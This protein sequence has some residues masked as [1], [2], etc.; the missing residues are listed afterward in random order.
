MTRKKPLAVYGWMDENDWDFYRTDPHI[1][2]S[3]YKTKRECYSQS[4]YLNPGKAVRVK[5]VEVKRGRK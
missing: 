3:V 1:E 4:A 2:I 5:I